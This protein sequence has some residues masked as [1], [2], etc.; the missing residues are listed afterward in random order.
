VPRSHP[1]RHRRRVWH[2]SGGWLRL[3]LPQGSLQLTQGRSL[4]RRH[5]GRSPQRPPRRRQLRRLGRPLLR[6][7]LHHGL[8]A[9]EGGSLELHRR[10][11]RHRRLPRHAPGLPRLRSRRRLRWH[12]PRPHRGRRDHAQQVPQRA[13][14]YAHHDGRATASTAAGGVGGAGV[15]GWVVRRR[16]KGRAFHRFWK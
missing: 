1:G 16:E 14:A 15:D 7:R 10:G 8:R 13:A 6:L 9:P 5:P 12:P 3:P 2:G 4:R 11:G